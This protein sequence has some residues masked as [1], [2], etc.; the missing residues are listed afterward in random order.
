MQVSK[1]LLIA[2]HDYEDDN[3]EYNAFNHIDLN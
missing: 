3:M 1:N 2:Y